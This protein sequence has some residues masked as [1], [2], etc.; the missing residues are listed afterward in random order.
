[1]A[2]IK[3]YLLTEKQNKDG[4]CPVVAQ[5][6]F[7]GVRLKKA[8]G[9]KAKP[10][11]WNEGKQRVKPNLKT[12]DYNEYIEYNSRLDDLQK[13][14][15]GIYNFALL[16]NIA[17]T[18]EYFEKEWNKENSS[19]VI[20]K[21]IFNYFDEYIKVH[22]AVRAKRTIM[23]H[24][25]SYN[26]LKDFTDHY[27]MNLTLENFNL[28]VFEKLRTYAFAEKGI[29][30]NTFSTITSRYKAF[31]RWAFERDYHKNMAFQKFKAPEREKDI[32]CLYKD[33]LFALY[34]KEFESKKLERVRDVYCF[35]CFTGLRFSDILDLREE[36]I[37]GDEI[38]KVIVKTRE[39]S[40]IPLN[41][42]ALEILEKYKDYP[43]GIL[44]T[45]SEQKFNTYIKNACEEAGVTT[46][47]S[48]SRFSGGKIVH[49]A[50]PKYKLI[51]SHTARKT[52]TT[53]SLILGM[54]ETVV[55]KI[56]GHKRD[57]NFRKYVRLAEDYIKEESNSAWNNI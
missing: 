39:F 48:V 11:H 54:N 29:T 50:F 4:L 25:T 45:I 27:K 33:E 16:N 23:G 5:L 49:E 15:T 51:T 2:A 12:E 32:I 6:T 24:T 22:E 10:K 53:N 20:A 1:M 46:M 57:D 30:D 47:V 52:F 13:K 55:K 31:M 17:L 9:V 41:K 3:F 19:T 42:Y 7:N 43:R 8:T 28:E 56:T 37:V 36:H 18:K 40:R 26:F 14:A 35:G 21:S 44:P 34:Y 38:Q